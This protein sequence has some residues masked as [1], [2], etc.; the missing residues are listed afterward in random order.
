MFL[1]F[2]AVYVCKE[3]VEHVLLLHGPGEDG[4]ADGAGAHGSAHGSMGHGEAL[5]LPDESGHAES[6]RLF[7]EPFSLLTFLRVRRIGIPTGVLLICFA[8]SLFSALGSGNHAGLAQAAGPSSISAFRSSSGARPSPANALLSALANPFVLI[9]LL[10][11]GG[12]AV[13]SLTLTRYAPRR[14][15]RLVHR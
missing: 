13:S 7:C 10:F 14:A 2:S 8:L 6:V 15:S 3:S 4:G 9:T 5:A 11:S 1:L 12:V